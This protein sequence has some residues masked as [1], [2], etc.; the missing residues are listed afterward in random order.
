MIA[1]I[2]EIGHF[3]AQNHCFLTFLQL[4]SLLDIPD[5]V[6]DESIEKFQCFNVWILFSLDEKPW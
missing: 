6:L 1:K 3:W 4:C 2:K 5:I